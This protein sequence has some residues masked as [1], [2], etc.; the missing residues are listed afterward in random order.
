[1]LQ[2]RVCNRQKSAPRHAEQR[3]PDREDT[4]TDSFEKGG[5]E[6][7]AFQK[8]WMESISKTMQAAF[9][10]TPDSAPP[11]VLRQI[12]AGIF[13]ALAESWDQ[14][15]R[16]PQ[17]LDGMRQWMENAIAFRKISNE[18]LGRARND[19]QAPSRSDIDT[20]ML[21]VRHMEKRLLDRLDELS[22]RIARQNGDLAGAPPH[23]APKAKGKRSNRKSRRAK[24]AAAGRSK[25]GSHE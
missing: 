7:A 9:R 6:A 11:E 20:V 3:K 21:A 10:F 19:L 8:I 18:F 16:S 5:P 13:Q 2:W 17:F 24:L 25:G 23:R 12:R 14:F 15:M 22:A 4:M 1:M